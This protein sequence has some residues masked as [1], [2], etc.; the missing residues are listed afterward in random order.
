MSHRPRRVLGGFATALVLLVLAAAPVAAD[1]VPQEDFSFSQSGLSADASTEV[2]VENADA[3][4]T[5]SG[6]GVFLFA[7]KARVGGEGAIRGAELCAQAFTYTLV[8]ATGEAID[9]SNEFGCTMDLGA[10][11]VIAKDLSTATLTPTTVTIQG[12]TCDEISCVPAGTP[13]D[14]VVE[15]TW[16]GVGQVVREQYRSVTDD[17]VCVSR[18]RSKGSFREATFAGTF[19]G[20]PLDAQY[21][22]LRNGKFSFSVSCAI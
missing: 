10:G 19:D 5:C 14:I 13:R 8:T 15:G 11:S 22:S 16:T 3:T 4:A 9:F 18:D 1:T 7:G 2:C 6:T 20:Q 17:G 12:E 21:A